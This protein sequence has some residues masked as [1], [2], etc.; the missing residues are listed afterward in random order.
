[1][2]SVPTG[3]GQE[4][5]KRKKGKNIKKLKTSFRQY[6]FPNRAEIGRERVKKIFVLNTVPTR[7]G[8]ENSNKKNKKIKKHH[9]GII[10]IQARLTR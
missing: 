2:N 6:F 1:M 3:P 9:S 8:I 5:E 10:S 4:N 7:P